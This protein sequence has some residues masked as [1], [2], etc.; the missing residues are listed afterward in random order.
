MAMISSEVSSSGGVLVLSKE[1]EVKARFRDN[2]KEISEYLNYERLVPLL[3][4]GPDKTA[5]LSFDDGQSLLCSSLSKYVKA[6]QLFQTL[7]GKYSK[8]LEC[9]KREGDHL[10]HAFICDLLEGRQHASEKEMA[11]SKAVKDAIN[12]ETNHFH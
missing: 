4:E 5:L 8:L 10:G 9:I 11:Y 1:E 6:S 3:C 7:E 12:E 2:L